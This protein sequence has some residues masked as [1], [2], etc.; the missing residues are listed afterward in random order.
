MIRQSPVACVMMLAVMVAGCGVMKQGQNGEP[1]WLTHRVDR[2][3]AEPAH[4][5]ALA[6]YDAL[7]TELT[8]VRIAAQELSIN[9]QFDQGDGTSPSAAQPAIPANLPAFSLEGVKPS[10]SVVVDFHFCE[11]TGKDREG[12]EIQA[13][14][15]TNPKGNEPPASVAIQVGKRRDDAAAN[16]L[17]AKVAERVARPRLQP[18]SPEEAAALQDLFGPRPGDAFENARAI[19][20]GKLWVRRSSL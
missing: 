16:A 20:E 15:W 14:V 4:R 5:V 17:L 11:I 1:V 8:S 3:F 10:G 13:V 2:G 19:R 7:S 18:A 6:T 12:R 9:S